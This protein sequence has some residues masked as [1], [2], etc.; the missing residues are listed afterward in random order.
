MPFTPFHFGPGA[1]IQAVFPKQLS[2]IAFALGNV[3]M[4]FEPAYYMLTGQFPLHRFFHSFLGATLVVPIVVFMFVAARRIAVGRGWVPN[5][6]D[7]LGLTVRQVCLGA[8]I[9][10]N[11]HIV[12]DGIMHSDVQ[13]FAPFSSLNPFLHLLPLDR[14]HWLCAGAAVLAFAVAMV[15][16]R[17]SVSTA[18]EEC[19][20]AK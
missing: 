2:F 7:W 12:L 1:A 11:S 15:R 13:P 18:S 19:D 4:D 16:L 9:G 5:L 6:Y 10:V 14:L 3:L 8:T 17:R 20:S